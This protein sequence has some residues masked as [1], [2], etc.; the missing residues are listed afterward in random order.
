MWMFFFMVS[1]LSI[2]ISGMLP[3]AQEG[4]DIPPEFGCLVQYSSSPNVS[5]K[6]TTVQ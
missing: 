3:D 6:Y 5:E 2:V 4:S 1:F